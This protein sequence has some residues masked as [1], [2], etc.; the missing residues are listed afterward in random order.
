LELSN[1]SRGEDVQLVMVT[2]I[3]LGSVSDARGQLLLNLIENV[4]QWKLEYF[5]L[6]GDIFDFCQGTNPYFQKK[7]QNLGVALELLATGGTK[8]I[9]VEG[10]HEFDLAGLPWKGVEFLTEIDRVIEFKSGLRMALTH[11]DQI[12]NNLSYRKFRALVKSSFV[13]WVA[14]WIVPPR[15]LDWYTSRHSHISRAADKYRHLDHVAL[16]SAMRNWLADKDALHG[17]FGHFHVPYFEPR[18]DATTGFIASCESWEIP[19]AL[20]LCQEK[21]SRLF[22]DRHTSKWVRKPAVSPDL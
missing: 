21:F 14:R 22:W 12:Y 20:I 17:V 6:C 18:N 13:R 3:H 2:D 11:G 16:V 4:R 10:N 8:V 1:I 9:F 19:N 7:F 5:L 15:L